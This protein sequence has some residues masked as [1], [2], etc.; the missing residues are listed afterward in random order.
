MA[1]VLDV[2]LRAEYVV[3]PG[4][5]CVRLCFGTETVDAGIVG[6]GSDQ[7]RLLNEDGS[8]GANTLSGDHSVAFA[9]QSPYFKHAST[10]RIQSSEFTINIKH[11]MTERCRQFESRL[12]QPRRVHVNITV[13]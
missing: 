9:G 8:G 10:H 3:A 6:G 2:C 1:C 4:T 5:R 7:T 11:N 13:E 12:V